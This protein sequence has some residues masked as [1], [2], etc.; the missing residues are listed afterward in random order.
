MRKTLVL[1]LSAVLTACGGGGGAG[2][3]A[4][5]VA[6]S[7]RHKVADLS[8]SNTVYNTAVGDLNGD[9]LDDVVVSG[10]NNDVATS[11][12]WVLIQNADGTLTDR[13]SAYLPTNVHAGSQHVFIADFDGD[14]KNDIFLPGFID[15]SSVAP[16]AS[17]MYWNHAGQFT[18]QIFAEQAM[19]HGACI[20]DLNHDGRLDM[21]VAGVGIYYNQGNRTFTVDSTA[22]QGNNYFSTCSVL[23]QPNGNVN[24]LLGN[25]GGVP[26][27][28]DGILVYNSAMVFQSGIGVAK[29]TGEDLIGSTAVDTNQDGFKDFVLVYNGLSVANA[30]KV[31]VNNGT[32]YT[33]GAT[34]DVLSND[35]HAYSLN[36][37]GTQAVFFPASESDSRLYKASGTGLVVHKPNSFS[38]A[39]TKFRAETTFCGGCT[40]YATA[41]TVYQNSNTGKIYMLQLMYGAF[42]TQEM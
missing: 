5:A 8:N 40:W 36:I 14:G 15:G 13:T 31:L 3:T 37:A 19:A 2:P 34:V 24:V 4:P 7:A 17:T 28:L 38:E 11:Y 10:W 33:A 18:Q 22:L 35:Y 25:H 21:I 39:I 23:H 42:Y 20:D 26:G 30:R 27:Y 9:N 1:L 16:A 6:V 12:V 32:V 29:N 41:S